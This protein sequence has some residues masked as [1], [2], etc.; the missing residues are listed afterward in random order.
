MAAFQAL[1]AFISTF[2]DPSVTGLYFSD[3]GIL[4]ATNPDDFK[5]KL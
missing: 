1:G 4:I 5:Q 2:A 3:E